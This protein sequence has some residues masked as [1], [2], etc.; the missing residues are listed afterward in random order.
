MSHGNTTLQAIEPAKV[1][2][3]VGASNAA[4][5]DPALTSYS[6]HIYLLNGQVY[7]PRFQLLGVLALR[8]SRVLVVIH[9]NLIDHTTKFP[10]L[11]C[12]EAVT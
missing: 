9:T 12:F 11:L 7:S 8:C 1:L 2:D 10:R 5:S 6:R 3:M 4:I